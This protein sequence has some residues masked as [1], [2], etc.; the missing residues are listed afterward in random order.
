MAALALS[1][2]V[3]PITKRLTRDGCSTAVVL[4]PI[5]DNWS[6]PIKNFCLA[7]PHVQQR[8]T[9]SNEGW[10]TKLHIEFLLAAESRA[11]L[12]CNEQVVRHIEKRLATVHSFNPMALDLL[13]QPPTRPFWL[14]LCV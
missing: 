2:V 8:L 11:V 12:R 5:G 6:G 1:A 13:K 3:T 9:T 14:R 10:A 7:Q 4:L